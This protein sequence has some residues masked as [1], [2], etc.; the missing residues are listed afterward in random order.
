M[1]LESYIGLTSVK[2]NKK[3]YLESNLLQIYQT[4]TLRFNIN[5]EMTHGNVTHLGDMHPMNSVTT[6]KKT[7]GSFL[8]LFMQ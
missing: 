7:T 4:S 1:A 3:V 2:Q 5:N 6:D 8:F